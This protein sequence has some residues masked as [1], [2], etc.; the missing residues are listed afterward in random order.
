MIEPAPERTRGGGTNIFT[1]RIGP[2]PMWVWVAI[3]AAGLIA[4]RV[5]SGKSSSQ[6]ATTTPSTPA[7]QVPPPAPRRHHQSG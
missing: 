4:W 2:L 6:Q 5:F 1:N 3:V 7:D